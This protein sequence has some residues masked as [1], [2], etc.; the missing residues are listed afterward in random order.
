MSELKLVGL[1]GK[2]RAGK[3]SVAEIL[4]KDFGFKQK[5]MAGGIR[6]ILLGLNPIVK[7]NGGV[8]WELLDL[9]DQYHGDWDRIKAVCSESTELMIK[10]GQTCRNVLGET[11]W[12]DRV[13][14]DGPIE[15]SICISDVRQPNE[16]MA[17]K[18]RGGVIWKISRPGTKP[19]GMDGLL[20]RFE[21]DFHIENRGSLTDLR[22]SVQ[23][24]IANGLEKRR[25]GKRF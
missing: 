16:Y 20:D 10:L 21:F 1:Y 13:L 9:Y 5:A 25:Y 3:D 6:E 2:S 14:P 4:V 17:I 8:V 11:V 18:A 7:D 12:L 19:R 24:A 15:G 22:G 23:A